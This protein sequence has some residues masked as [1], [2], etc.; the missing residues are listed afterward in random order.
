MASSSVFTLVTADIG[1][2]NARFECWSTRRGDASAEPLSLVLR[3]TYRP[4]SFASLTPLL[5]H[6]LADAS[7]SLPSS[8]SPP[9]GVV[10]ARTV[11]AVCGPCWDG[12]RKNESNNI[13]GWCPPGSAVS[14]NDASAVEAALALPANSVT[15]INDFEAVGWGV[16][17]LRDRDAP[18]PTRP[19][20]PL[21]LHAA[22]AVPTA[23]SCCVG[24]GT[25]L[26][27]CVVV[28][29]PAS[30]AAG[31]GFTVLPSEAGMTDTISPKSEAEWRLLQ[32]LRRRVG[33][34]YVE[35]ERTATG[36]G[37]HD[38]LA[39]L[40]E[41]N[42]GEGEGEGEGVGRLR[43]EA[44]AELSQAAEEE[45]AA[46]ISKWAQ[47]AGEPLCLEAIDLFLSFYGRFLCTSANTFLPYGG[48][49]IAGGILPKLAWRLPCLG[50][51]GAGGG[52]SDGGGDPLL[53]GF[54]DGGPKMSGTVARVPLWLIGDPDVGLKGCLYVALQRR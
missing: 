24:A 48:L 45:K 27:A 41:E 22:E 4:S 13:P 5:A 16:A 43:P 17:A 40:Q 38:I 14:F 7:A 3:S 49:Y 52:R 30:S 32:F 18:E 51:G 15:F 2:T 36:P 35:V 34:P 44:E 11:L 46:V 6:F 47:E 23:P 31:A 25:G 39:W 42:E 19:S 1:G 50:G 29:L 28:P 33:S 9:T 10:P 21:S 8:S 53:R 37:I 26:G 12:G 54:L 20:A